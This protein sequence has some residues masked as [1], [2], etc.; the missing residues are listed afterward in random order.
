MKNKVKW[1]ILAVFL[2]GI[3]GGAAALYYALREDYSPNNPAAQNEASSEKKYAAPD[4]TVLDQNVGV[5]KEGILL[6]AGNNGFCI[7]D[8]CFLSHKRLPF[9]FAVY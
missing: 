7:A 2:I 1:I 6:I 3:I 9:P 8:Q 4:F 5:T